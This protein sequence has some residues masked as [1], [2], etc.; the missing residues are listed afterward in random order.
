MRVVFLQDVPGVAH[1][2]DV[3]TVKDGFA[4]NY[5]IP[6]SLAVPATQDALRR[7]DRLKKQAEEDRIKAIQDMRTLAELLNSAQVNIEMRAGTN[8]RLYGSV[9][10][11]I[12]AEKLSEMTGREI[13]RRVVAMTEPFRQVGLYE[14][15]V[16]LHPEVDA[17][18]KVLV[19]PSGTD[20]NAVLAQGE[21]QP[22]EAATPQPEPA[23]Q[24]AAEAA[25]PV[26]TSGEGET[27]EVKA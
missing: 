27:E 26:E 19:Y 3:R 18:V 16:H 22:A 25:A 20:P 24:D 8:G 12:V 4:R 21:G 6:R 10:N 5:L 15:D 1:G 14:V 17:R 23:A 7:V 9:T 11:A 2:G 13:D